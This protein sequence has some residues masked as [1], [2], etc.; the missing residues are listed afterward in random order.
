MPTARSKSA[1]ETATKRAAGRKG[2]AETKSSGTKRTTGTKRGT[3]IAAQDSRAARTGEAVAATVANTVA[4]RT[5]DEDK[6]V[7]AGLLKEGESASDLLRRALRR[8]EREAL[9]DQM[10]A[11]MAR[12]ADEDL[13]DEP[14]DWTV[15]EDGTIIDHHPIPKTKAAR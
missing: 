2:A 8:L 1:T 9:R 10:Y 7:I 12:L 15:A 14:D 3:E 13:S 5:S 6:R 11:D 4:F